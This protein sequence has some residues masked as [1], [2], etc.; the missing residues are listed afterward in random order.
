MRS[1]AYARV[2]AAGGVAWFKACAPVQAFEPRLTTK[3]FA[4]WPDRVTEVL[5]YEEEC[6]RLLLADAGTPVGAAGNPPE[7]WLTASPRCAELQR[8]RRH[9]REIIWPTASPTC[10][11]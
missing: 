11:W 3:L 10:G 6:S 4:R 7:S 2:V 8:V 5:G 1:P 9:A